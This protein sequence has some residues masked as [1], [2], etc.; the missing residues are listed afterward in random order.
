MTATSILGGNAR[1]WNDLLQK[2]PPQGGCFS[3]HFLSLHNLAG[4]RVAHILLAE[5]RNLCGKLLVV[6]RMFLAEEEGVVRLGVDVLHTGLDCN[7]V[8]K[9]PG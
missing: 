1:E 3:F 5:L 8:R 2:Q 7:L 9:L 4:C 6:F